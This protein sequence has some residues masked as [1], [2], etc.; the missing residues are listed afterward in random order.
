MG[1]LQR[2]VNGM[3]VTS[4]VP[5]H[6]CTTDTNEVECRY[7]RVS[8]KAT[9]KAHVAAHLAWMAGGKAWLRQGSDSTDSAN[10]RRPGK[11]ELCFYWLVLVALHIWGH[12]WVQSEA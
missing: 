4:E 1:S 2:A 10:Q 11:S 6:R 9:D 8:S 7:S 3:T 5:V 12:R